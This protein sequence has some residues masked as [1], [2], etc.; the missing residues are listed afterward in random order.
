MTPHTSPSEMFEGENSSL[1]KTF[2]K[3][4]SENVE[5]CQ[6]KKWTT[7]VS[8]RKGRRKIC[9][10]CGIEWKDF[11]LTSVP[12]PT[13]KNVKKWS[14]GETDKPISH[15]TECTDKNSEGTHQGCTV[16]HGHIGC[17]KPILEEWEQTI[18][19]SGWWP[20][21]ETMGHR[22]LEEF[23]GAIGNLLSSQK[24]EMEIAHAY[25]CHNHIETFRKQVIEKLKGIKRNV[26]YKG[27]TDISK[28]LTNGAEAYGFNSA[29]TEAQ[30]IIKEM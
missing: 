5:E 30:K 12:T 16:E 19:N 18:R 11:H 25:E 9:N 26:S 14:C 13:T 24:E 6:H 3:A 15:C 17:N 20:H 29:L 1:R 10:N 8:T 22:S 23:L 27:G 4:T 21:L 7:S 2:D 28:I